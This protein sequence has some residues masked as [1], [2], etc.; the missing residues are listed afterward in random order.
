MEEVFIGAYNAD[1]GARFAATEMHFVAHVFDTFYDV[2]DLLRL[3]V[4]FHYNNHDSILMLSDLV[5]ASVEA[6]SPGESPASKPCTVKS[7]RFYPI[8]LDNRA[9]IRYV[10]ALFTVA[11][12]CLRRSADVAINSG[13]H[14]P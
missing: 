2:F 14:T 3:G 9:Q 10:L 13:S 7:C 11:I 4:L 1:D 12:L 6:A 5:W 8:E